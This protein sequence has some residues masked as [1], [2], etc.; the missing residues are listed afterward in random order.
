ME[1]DIFQIEL[2][3]E[4][5][6]ML[7]RL[8]GDLDLAA[9]EPLRRLIDLLALQGTHTVLIDASDAEFIDASVVGTLFQLAR[10]VHERGGAISLVD[11]R[12]APRAIWDLTGWSELC[13]PLPARPVLTGPN[14]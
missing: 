8:A 9:Q 3:R 1:R 14:A 6:V 12:E 13:P 4:P 7:L 2:R 10:E 11:A 5:S